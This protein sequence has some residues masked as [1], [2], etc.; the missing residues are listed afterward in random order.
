MLRPDGACPLVT[1]GANERHQEVLPG[2]EQ[3]QPADEAGTTWMVALGGVDVVGD[4]SHDVKDAPMRA[5]RL[6][7]LGLGS[8][9]ISRSGCPIAGQPAIDTAGRVSDLARGSSDGRRSRKALTV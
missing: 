6:D 5:T 2:W 3:G 4:P 1:P 8:P 9:R 7:T